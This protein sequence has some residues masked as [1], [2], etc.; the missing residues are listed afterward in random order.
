MTTDTEAR[1]TPRGEAYDRA[2]TEIPGATY[3]LQLGPAFGFAKAEEFLPYLAR[4]GVTD[5]YLSPIFAA[6]PGSEHGYDVTDH[7]AISAVLGG[8]PA[9]ASLG[10]ALRRAGMGQVIDVVPNHM[11]VGH[12]RSNAWWWD[13]LENGEC[14][15]YARY[16]DI[17]WRPVKDELRD[18]VLLPV[19]G[20]QY[21]HVLE[22]GELTLALGRGTLTLRYFDHEFPVN[23]RTIPDILRPGLDDG[24]S[25]LARDDPD[26]GEFLSV[27]TSLEN[28]PTRLETDPERIAE[29]QRE[30]EVARHRLEQ[31]LERS[32]P[33]RAFV[34]DRIRACNGEP[35]HPGSFDALHVV[36]ERQAYRLAYWRTAFHEI[37]YRRFFDVNSLASL[38]VEEPEA[39]QAS[40]R[41]LLDLLR[42]GPPTGVRLDHL[43]GLN[44]PGAYVRQLRDAGRREPDDGDGAPLYLLA[45]KIFHPGEDLP[46]AWG[47]H[48]TTGYDYLAESDG[49]YVDPVGWRA[50]HTFY[51]RF[52][53]RE[54]SFEEVIYDSKRAVLE[55]TLASELNLLAH[56][57]NR[58][59]E[60]DRRTRDF[61]LNSLRD[62]LVEVIACFPVYR[63]Y[64]ERGRHR[65]EDRAVI[66]RA[67]ASARRR[68]PAMDTSIFDFFVAVM[69]DDAPPDLPETERAARRDFTMKFQQYTGP[70]QAKGVED[71]AFY[72]HV[73]LVS[74]N[75]VGGAPDRPTLTPAAYHA[76]ALE[77]RAR[78]PHGMLATST[79]DTKRSEDVRARLNVLSELAGP[80]TKEVSRWA[81]LHGVNRS[82]VEGERA[83]DRGDEYLFYQTL[84]GIWPFGTVDV[85]ALVGRLKEYM[86]KAIREAKLHTSWIHEH[87]DYERAV[88]D[89]VERTL[90]GPTAPAFLE[91]FLPF[92]A[93]V[94]ACG[95][96]NSLSQLLLKLVAPGVPDLYQGTELWSL[97]LV[98]PDNRRPVDYA[99]RDAMMPGVD[100]AL[101]PKRSPEERAAA[102]ADALGRW[103]DGGVKLLVTAAG[104]RLR[105]ACAPLFREGDYVPLEVEGARA[106]HITALA[107]RHGDAVIVAAAPRLTA[108]FP[109]Q[110]VHLDTAAWGD[111]RVILP[112]DIAGRSYEDRLTGASR[113]AVPS[114]GRSAISAASLFASFPV[115]LLKAT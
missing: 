34:E 32:A 90:R 60:G 68:N 27:L 40:H 26:R 107:R 47:L 19:L 59:S 42:S 62:M 6:S 56:D 113:A 4:L 79:H 12:P 69:L 43:D 105:R 49:L 15:P 103:E 112:P 16:F 58:L 91:S 29:R 65:P 31:L 76:R 111:T 23:P 67:V 30:K 2:S 104:L 13:V 66:E 89:F 10:A 110:G 50:L 99:L 3:R 106:E 1:A 86:R 33:L 53:R 72:R 41:L 14:S 100:A 48:G 25:R 97:A 22:R 98:D 82:R 55:S 44:D 61:T 28:L 81:R 17:D 85:E 74:R 63:T 45:E 77:R 5:L 20:D 8:A 51:R 54:G 102:I 35:G 9:F 64:I 21:G 78:W 73:V 36:L 37:N 114:E 115:A 83:P 52:T 11:G 18:K 71:T 109:R 93:R 87:L 88:D 75:E 92:Q 101:D 95:A 57:L 84:I 39:F 46:P 38:R 96:T 24:R 94:A 80:W 70:A 7:N 108:S